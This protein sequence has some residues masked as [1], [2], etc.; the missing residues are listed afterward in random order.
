MKGFIN[1]FY[2]EILSEL[3]VLKI[4]DFSMKNFSDIYTN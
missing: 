2:D 4:F 1:S 3:S